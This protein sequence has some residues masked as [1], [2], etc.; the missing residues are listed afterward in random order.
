MDRFLPGAFL[1]GRHLVLAGEHELDRTVLAAQLR[2]WGARVTSMELRAPDGPLPDCDA[3][4]LDA[5][6]ALETA[7][8]IAQSVAQQSRG[9][10]P[11]LLLSAVQPPGGWPTRWVEKPTRLDP[12]R[13]AIR[14]ALGA[15]A[16]HSGAPAAAH[17][18][19]RPSDA[20]HDG[21]ARPAA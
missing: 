21:L 5:D 4:L 3:V 10:I 17:S 7:F 8:E 9:A 16:T 13:D 1:A 19:G 11:V 2:S 20:N 15:R 14:E 12:L 18:A 6:R